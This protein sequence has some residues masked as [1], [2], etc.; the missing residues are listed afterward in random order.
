[1]QQSH[2][3]VS[4]KQD[5]ETQCPLQT[6]YKALGSNETRSLHI[7]ITQYTESTIDIVES[8]DST[9]SKYIALFDR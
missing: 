6:A 8:C 1:M 4:G 7:P 5:T 3:E 9:F 2:A